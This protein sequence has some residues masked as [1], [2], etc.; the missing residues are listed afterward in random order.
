MSKSKIG[1][2]ID[3]LKSED[4]KRRANSIKSFTTIATAIGP[5]RTRS[6]LIPF[7]NGN[8]A[9]PPNSKPPSNYTQSSLMMK[10]TS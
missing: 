4:S 6:D 8:F 2:L 9:F 10:T 3:E 1:V 7:V 5:E